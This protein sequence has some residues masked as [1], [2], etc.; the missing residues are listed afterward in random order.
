MTK[1]LEIWT[2]LLKILLWLWSNT[3]YRIICK[4]KMLFD[5]LFTVGFPRL[6]TLSKDINHN[7]FKD[8][9]LDNL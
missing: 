2:A 8:Y 6:E 3:G 9:S 4:N 7:D 5:G 1:L